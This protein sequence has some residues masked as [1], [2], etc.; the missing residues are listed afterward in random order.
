MSWFRIDGNEIIFSS[1]QNSLL[2]VD[3]EKR[4]VTDE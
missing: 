4:N 1:C 2:R 3:G